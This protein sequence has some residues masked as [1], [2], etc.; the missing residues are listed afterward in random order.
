M[1]FMFALQFVL[2]CDTHT[3]HKKPFIFGIYTLQHS[4]QHTATNHTLQGCSNEYKAH[5]FLDYGREAM[6]FGDTAISRKGSFLECCTTY[7]VWC[8]AS[9][10]VCCSV[11]Q[12]VYSFHGV[13][14][15]S[16][17][18]VLHVTTMA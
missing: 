14:A 16:F 4:L 18:G 6:D 7:S 15:Y 9:V 2:R 12:C 3:L 5:V 10:V 11:M 17:H 8:V 1:T 13:C